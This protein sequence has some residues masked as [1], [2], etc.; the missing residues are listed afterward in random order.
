M[1]DTVNKMKAGEVAITFLMSKRAK[2]QLDDMAK[3]INTESRSE[4]IRNALKIY[5]ALLDLMDGDGDIT[6]NGPRGTFRM[7][8][9]GD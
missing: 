7:N 5:N 4:V 8:M 1:I 6:I 9:K 3:V 2:N